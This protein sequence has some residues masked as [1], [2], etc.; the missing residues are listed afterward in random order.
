MPNE[1][2]KDLVVEAREL[3]KDA[4]PRP[5]LVEV[6]DARGD[7][8]KIAL[9]SRNGHFE[10]GYYVIA[11]DDM[12]CRREQAI[13]D[14]RAIARAPELLRQL[15]NEVERLR[16]VDGALDEIRNCDKCDLCED[17]HD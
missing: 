12:F 1:P 5:W 2:Q 16:G 6:H 14:F 10:T 15:A 9:V 4:S 13:A 3:F 11:D 8:A 17:H 7:Y